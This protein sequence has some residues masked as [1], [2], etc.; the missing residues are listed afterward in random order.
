MFFEI[1]PQQPSGHPRCLGRKPVL[2]EKRCQCTDFPH[3][4]G[5]QQI[6]EH[7]QTP[8]CR[9][10]APSTRSHRR[11]LS[12]ALR[13]IGSTIVSD[14]LHPETCPPSFQR[15]ARPRR[16]VGRATCSLFTPRIH[17]GIRGFFV[18]QNRAVTDHCLEKQKRPANSRSSLSPGGASIPL[19]KRPIKHLE[20]FEIFDFYLPPQNLSAQ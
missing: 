19:G 12:A 14:P 5:D 7:D 8:W 15:V 11:N 9:K 18:F 1:R 4:L 13:S 17:I 3:T 10:R 20:F 6:V 16:V 2:G